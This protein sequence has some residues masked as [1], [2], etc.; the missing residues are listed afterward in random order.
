M[1]QINRALTYTKFILTK[2]SINTN[3]NTKSSYK[4][5][6]KFIENQNNYRLNIQMNE[7]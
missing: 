2:Q 3:Y 4:K 6:I 1:L 5:L 7:Q